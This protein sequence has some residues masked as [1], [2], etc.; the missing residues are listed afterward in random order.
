MLMHV[1]RLSSKTMDHIYLYSSGC[2][3]PKLYYTSYTFIQICISMLT[4]L[5]FAYV[6]WLHIYSYCLWY[7]DSM[8]FWYLWRSVICIFQG[9]I[10]GTVIKIWRIFT[11]IVE[12]MM[13]V[14]HYASTHRDFSIFIAFQNYTQEYMIFINI[15]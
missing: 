9:R 11:K 15:G 2:F 1:D 8:V 3:Y 4:L 14:F 10:K 6:N 13:F 7:F 5:L 12:I